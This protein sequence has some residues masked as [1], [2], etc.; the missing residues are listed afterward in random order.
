MTELKARL[1]NTAGEMAKRPK[2]L[3]DEIMDMVPQIAKALPRH[4]DAQRMGRIILTEVRK[5]PELAKCNKLSLFGSLLTA[6]QIG[7]EPGPLGFCYLIPYKGQVSLQLGYRG[8]LE[9]VSRSDRVDSVYAYA[10]YKGDDFTYQLGTHPDIQH[11]RGESVDD[12]EIIAVYAVAHIKGSTIPR[13]EVMTRKQVDSIR[14]RAQARSNGPWVTDYGEMARKTVL[15]KLCK[16]LPLSSEIAQSLSRD[17]TI[18]P[19]IEAEEVESMFE[20]QE[21]EEVTNANEASA[22]PAS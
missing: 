22:V 18:R 11:V 13:I 21:I 8:L 14:A 15:K 6:S 16:T 17:E 3:S 19:S 5:N 4:M 9:L 12:A 1:K 7:L 20:V 10:V 2:T